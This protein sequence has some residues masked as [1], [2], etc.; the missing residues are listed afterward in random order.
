MADI[1]T[2]FS[3]FILVFLDLVALVAVIEVLRWFDRSDS[4]MLGINL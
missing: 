4:D 2:G 3:S 1:C